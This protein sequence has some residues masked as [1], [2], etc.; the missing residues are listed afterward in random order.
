MLT[1]LIKKNPKSTAPILNT[2]VLDNTLFTRTSLS[3]FKYFKKDHLPLFIAAPQS[4][5]DSFWNTQSIFKKPCLHVWKAEGEKAC[6]P[7]SQQPQ[8]PWFC[9]KVAQDVSLPSPSVTAQLTSAFSKDLLVCPSLPWP[10]LT[11]LAVSASLRGITFLGHPLKVTVLT[12]HCSSYYNSSLYEPPHFTPSSVMPLFSTGW[13]PH[14]LQ[15]DQHFIL[16]C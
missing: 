4:V 14:N 11:S 15:D 2:P 5:P 16:K 12:L 1:F 13:K 3:Y 9:R 6:F 8:W 7:L 10:P